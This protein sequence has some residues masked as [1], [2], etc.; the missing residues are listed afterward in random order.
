MNQVLLELEAVSRTYPGA[1]PVH[2]V[3]SVN[4]SVRAGEFVSITGPSGSGKSTLLGLL[5]LLDQPTEGTIALTGV[6]VTGA[7]DAKRTAMRG[8]VLG[9]VFQQFH[10]IPHLSATGNVEVALLYR[11]LRP[12]ERRRLAH[13]ALERIG[14]GHRFD[15]RP[16][17]LS[18]GEQQR[19]A[20]AR[21]IVTEPRIVLADEPTGALDTTNADNIMD[22]L[23]G[24]VDDKTA[25]IMVTHD[26]E[27]A[28]RAS[29]RIRM[30][31]GA[32]VSD[33]AASD[34]PSSDAATSVAERS[35]VVEP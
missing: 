15:H 25:V 30:R 11:H 3:R 16:T 26:G 32:I 13:S 28:D 8:Q 6:D 21:A 2:A 33:G 19:V 7:T 4:L 34:R 9:F 29:R 31:D 35:S 1:E 17:E 27:L 23:N 20:I 24:L 5:G 12:I 14:L 22:V 18:G 10:L